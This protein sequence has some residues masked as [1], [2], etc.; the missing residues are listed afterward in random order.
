[1]TRTGAGQ[2]YTWHASVKLIA[3]GLGDSGWGWG[4]GAEV[5]RRGYMSGGV[6][7]SGQNLIEDNEFGLNSFTPYY[8]RFP[9]DRHAGA[10]RTLHATRIGPDRAA[11][12][13]E[14]DPR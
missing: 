10:H 11:P 14:R 8:Y 3:G 5:R 7:P 9:V 1:M 13:R 6:T 4:T 2:K 12:T